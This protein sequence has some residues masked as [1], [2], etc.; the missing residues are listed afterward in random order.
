MTKL[1]IHF[2]FAGNCLQTT[3]STFTNKIHT[4]QFT[5]PCIHA[6]HIA[7]LTYCDL[8]VYI[9]AVYLASTQ[10]KIITNKPH[11]DHIVNSRLVI[12]SANTAMR[13]TSTGSAPLLKMAT[14]TPSCSPLT[15]LGGS[16]T[17]MYIDL[18]ESN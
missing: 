17:T 14:C 13:P 15:A 6:Q 18:V 10:L 1:K 9:Q 16:S 7:A 2:A 3:T 12:C 11:A 8:Y 4:M 5:Q